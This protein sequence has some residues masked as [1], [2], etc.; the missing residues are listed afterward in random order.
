MLLLFLNLKFRAFR[1]IFFL[2]GSLFVLIYTLEFI[3]FNNIVFRF[4]SPLLLIL[5]LNLRVET[6]AKGFFYLLFFSK[7]NV[8]LLQTTQNILCR[9]FILKTIRTWRYLW[10]KDEV[11]GKNAVLCCYFCGCV[12]FLQLWRYLH[13][14][15]IF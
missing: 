12:I 13:K 8:L 6:N 15:S 11:L 3:P 2:F 14:L 4:F 1:E 7:T 9:L 10:I 5:L